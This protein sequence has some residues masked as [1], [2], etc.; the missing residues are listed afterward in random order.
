MQ[1]PKRAKE[2]DLT[3]PPT[4]VRLNPDLGYRA[5]ALALKN[6][7]E[8]LPTNT[9]SKIVNLALEEYLKKRGA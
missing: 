6:K 1:K 2:K 9:F 5:R 4:T 3:F 7:H 8:G